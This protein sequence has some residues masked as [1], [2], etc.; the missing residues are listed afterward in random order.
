MFNFT[1]IADEAKH[2][3][4][5]VLAAAVLKTFP[6]AK[7]GVGPV[8]KQGFYYDFEIARK[9][10]EK[11]IEKIEK[12]A[13][14]IRKQG[15]NMQQIFMDKDEALN[16]V[17]QRGQIYKAELLKGIPDQDISFYKLDDFIDLCRGPHIKNTKELGPIKIVKVEESHW[18]DDES[19]PIL[20]RIYGLTFA[21]EPELEEYYLLKKEEKERDY[22]SVIERDNLGRVVGNSM[23]LNESGSQL[24]G[25]I[26]KL[27]NSY[28]WNNRF[29]DIYVNNVDNLEELFEHL[30]TA[31]QYKI[32]SPREFPITLKS[33]AFVEDDFL[34]ESTQLHRVI[35][36]KQYFTTLDLF[37]R[38]PLI[39]RIVDFF[40]A[41]DFD[42]RAEIFCSSDKDPFIEALSNILQKDGVS[43]TKV[44]SQYNPDIRIRFVGHDI[45]N[46]SWNISELIIKQNQK[47]KNYRD[48]LNVIH[49]NINPFR[50]LAYILENTKGKLPRILSP[51][52]IVII[53]IGKKHAEYAQA[54]AQFVN[55]LGYISSTDLTSKSINKK[56][57]LANKKNSTL[58]IIVGDKEQTTNSVSL[59]HLDKDLGLIKLEDL[60]IN[61]SKIL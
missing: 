56:V 25:K 59:R 55:N 27:I 40:K 30:D 43:H 54:V 7:I 1:P 42:L 45:L 49:M 36:V 15:H 26:E 57:F 53:P 24:L 8:T 34:N 38:M 3:A 32:R 60:S 41:L 16:M 5:H 17:L 29:T 11:D 48:N 6:K 23:L 61:L 35:A 22:T 13:N 51:N 58:Q 12:E 21:S 44:V 52:E 31:F 37:E 28:F 47:F 50:V 18:Q 19:R 10:S 14:K 39:N 4:A 9:I 33:Q 20:Q 46:R 2:T